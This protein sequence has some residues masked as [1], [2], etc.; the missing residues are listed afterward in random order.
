MRFHTIIEC[1]QTTTTFGSSTASWKRTQWFL[2][3]ELWNFA[4][5][6]DKMSEAAILDVVRK[7][8]PDHL[9]L[10]EEGGIIGDSSSGYLWCIDPLGMYLCKPMNLIFSYFPSF[11]VFVEVAVQKCLNFEVVF[12]MESIL[13][14]SL[15]FNG[16]KDNGA[17]LIMMLLNVNVLSHFSSSTSLFSRPSFPWILLSW[18]ARKPL[19]ATRQCEY[20]KAVFYD[21]LFFFTFCSSSS[22][23]FCIF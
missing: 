4:C 19:F 11:W 10:G 20:P 5:R 22:D 21:K 16:W 2:V 6:T 1:L 23:D 15:L 7:N 3:S 12:L 13:L 14:F 17:Y 18:T 9:I 8:F